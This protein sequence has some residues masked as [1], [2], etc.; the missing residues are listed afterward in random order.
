MLV[1]GCTGSV[2]GE[3]TIR[4]ETDSMD[5][6]SRFTFNSALI[7]PKSFPIPISY[8]LC[9]QM[10]TLIGETGLDCCNFSVC[11]LACV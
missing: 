3:Q 10:E 11:N 9:L 1:C 4:R 5:R 8:L 7:G 2:V 6:E